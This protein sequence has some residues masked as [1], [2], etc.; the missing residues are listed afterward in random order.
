[1]KWAVNLSSSTLS[2]S[3]I[4]CSTIRTTQN[5]FYRSSGPA[6]ITIH[7]ACP[8][9][10]T[11][12]IRLSRLQPLPPLQ[13]KVGIFYPSCF[14]R[15]APGPSPTD[16]HT[17]IRYLLL[18]LRPT[19]YV[20]VEYSTRL[21][22]ET[23]AFAWSLS[24]PQT[25]FL[26]LPFL[27]PHYYYCHHYST[28][29]STSTASTATTTTSVAS[30]CCCFPPASPL[31]ACSPAIYHHFPVSAES[32]FMWVYERVYAHA[33]IYPPPPCMI[34]ILYLYLCMACIFFFFFDKVQLFP[35]PF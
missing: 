17:R 35:I 29:T 24:P 4:N 5:D 14:V 21:R 27:L 3:A 7:T 26:P 18:L 23:C 20:C 9:L 19:L 6:G 2:Q 13:F 34:I 15:R 11:S 28:A 32:V 10:A 16:R 1:M 25:L 30:Y 8:Q 22:L 31:S 12:T 33:C